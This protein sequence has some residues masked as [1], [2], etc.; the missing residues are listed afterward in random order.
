MRNIK[1]ACLEQE[2]KELSLG[3]LELSMREV[4]GSK[5]YGVGVGNLAV[6]YV[7]KN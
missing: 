6:H 2:K 7:N 1:I 4:Y 3:E 5:V